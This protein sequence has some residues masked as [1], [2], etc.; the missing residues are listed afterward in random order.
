[1]HNH[2]RPIG[3]SFCTFATEANAYGLLFTK[4]IVQMPHTSEVQS[5][6][7]TPDRIACV[8]MRPALLRY[9]AWRECFTDLSTPLLLP[10]IGP[11]AAALDSLLVTMHEFRR[12]A[13][14]E[15]VDE[16]HA[17]LYFRVTEKEK[18]KRPCC[19]PSQF[20]M[21]PATDDD[22]EHYAAM[23]ERRFI[24]D[25]GT[26]RFNRFAEQLLFDDIAR[27]VLRE[28]ATGATETESI[29]LFLDQIGIA[30]LIEFEQAKKYA[31]RWRSHY[32][33]PIIRGNTMRPR[34]V[35]VDVAHRT[36]VRW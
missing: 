6:A 9:I 29:Q 3:R 32:N 11:V 2:L 8:A 13:P 10:G 33:A 18:V 17:R 22:E 5:P 30:D 19:K 31:W 16:F 24:T 12:S 25:A 27:F 15:S 28:K 7:Y 36:R 20:S 26:R 14:R 21:F 23:R 35:P 1:M 34:A 4:Q